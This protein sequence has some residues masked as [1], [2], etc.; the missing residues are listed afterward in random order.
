MS[1]GQNNSPKTNFEGRGWAWLGT[2][3][4]HCKTIWYPKKTITVKKH[5]LDRCNTLGP[6]FISISNSLLFDF[7][8]AILSSFSSDNDK[9]RH[10]HSPSFFYHDTRIVFFPQRNGSGTATASPWNLLGIKKLKHPFSRRLEFCEKTKK[11]RGI[12]YKFTPNTP[13]SGYLFRGL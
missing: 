3:T 6:R 12:R 13:H 4:K 7:Q 8:S 11:P 9:K 1:H 2:C 5:T 10:R